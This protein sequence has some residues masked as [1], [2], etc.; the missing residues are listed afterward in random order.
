[1]EAIR[2]ENLDFSYGKEQVLEKI[3]FSLPEGHFGLL[4][5]ENGAGKSTFLRLLLGELTAENGK[6]EIL[7]QDVRGF[8]DWQQ[9]SY[10]A[11]NGMTGWEDFPA[12]VEEIVQA[13]L[14]RRIGL[15]RFAGKKEKAQVRRALELVGME[16]FEKRLI[17]NLSGGQQQRIL[18][19]RALVNEPKLLVLD[20]PTSALDEKNAESFYQLLKKI[21]EKQKISIL[22][23]THDA[24]RAARY[25][26]DVWI[27]EDGK[28]YRKNGTAQEEREGRKNAD[29]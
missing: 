14:Y 4:L 28:M 11:Q 2:I 15:F 22:M 7:G 1:M 12:S 5:G 17:G 16:E 20:E 29:F 13:N 6:I 21:H 27:L 23:V 25:A 19:A 3:G 10:A 9:I 26:Q 8:K 18:L 24:K